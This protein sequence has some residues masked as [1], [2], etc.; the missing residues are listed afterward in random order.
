[1][2][3]SSWCCKTEFVQC[4]KILWRPFPSVQLLSFWVLLS[5]ITFFLGITVFFEQKS[6]EPIHQH[7]RLLWWPHPINLFYTIDEMYEIR[8]SWDMMWSSL[9]MAGTVKSFDSCP[10]FARHDINLDMLIWLSE[11]SLSGLFS[12]VSLIRDNQGRET[13]WLSKGLIIKPWKTWLSVIIKLFT[14]SLPSFPILPTIHQTNHLR[15]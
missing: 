14:T 11:S 5:S 9:P 6:N 8:A 1:M 3:F 4:G 2:H 15:E 13:V 7:T 10:S 12:E